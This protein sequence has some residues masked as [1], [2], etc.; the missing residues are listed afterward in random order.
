MRPMEM[1]RYNGNRLAPRGKH[2]RLPVGW[3]Q[4]NSNS[5]LIGITLK[6]RPDAKSRDLLTEAFCFLGAAG[7]T[8]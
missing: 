7:F 3:I 5:A 6:G 1:V 8:G 4:V 2:K